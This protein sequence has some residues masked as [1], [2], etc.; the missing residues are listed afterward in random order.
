MKNKRLYT[1]NRKRF[2]TLTLT[3]MYYL[4]AKIG[5]ESVKRRSLARVFRSGE[6]YQDVWVS[7]ESNGIL[8]TFLAYG[9]SFRFGC[10]AFGPTNSKVIRRWALAQS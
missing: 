9:D 1:H 2:V 8:R 5:N 10:C 3:R 7:P 6:S 4:D